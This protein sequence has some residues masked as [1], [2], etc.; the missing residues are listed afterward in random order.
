MTRYG[1]LVLAGL[2]HGI[3]CAQNTQKPPLEVTYIANEGFM[4]T[5]GSTK[6]LVDALPKSKYYANPSESLAAGM[7]YGTAPFDKVDFALV[8]HDHADHFNAEMMSSFLLNH[9]ATRFIANPETCRHLNGDSLSGRRVSAVDLKPGE[10][11]TIHGDKAEILILRL[12]HGGFSEISNLAFVVQANGYTIV[13]VGDARLSDNGKILRSVDWRSYN[14]DLLFVEYFDHSSET[15]DIIEHLIQP[16]H[17]ILMHIP[18]GEEN[19]V[20]NEDEKVHPQTVVFGK[21]S[22][23]RRFDNRSDQGSSR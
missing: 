18:E 6:V 13:H 8:T 7:I 5:M 3:G 10:Q 17:V 11:Q 12:L 20:Q 14:V 1:I 9:P 19:N 16:K 4:I 2:L 15:Q 22:E 21:E 23:T